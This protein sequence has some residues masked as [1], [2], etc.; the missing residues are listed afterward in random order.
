MIANLK[1]NMMSKQKSCFGTYGESSFKKFSNRKVAI[2]RYFFIANYFMLWHWLLLILLYYEGLK[3][4]VLFLC[5]FGEQ[6]KMMY[7][8]N[9]CSKLQVPRITCFCVLNAYTTKTFIKKLKLFMMKMQNLT[10]RLACAK[11]FKW[12]YKSDW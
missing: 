10:Q 7:Q 2:G 6:F 8:L 5:M 12:M 1:N 3:G 11:F 4:S 9:S